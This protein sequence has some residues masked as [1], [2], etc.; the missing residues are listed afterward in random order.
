MAEHVN[1]VT[2]PLCQFIS[3]SNLFCNIGKYKGMYVICITQTKTIFT[4]G[5]LVF[6]QLILRII[7]VFSLCAVYKKSQ[8]AAI[9]F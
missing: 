8:D 7:R 5:I 9:E 4:A 6:C 1:E 2:L 3:L